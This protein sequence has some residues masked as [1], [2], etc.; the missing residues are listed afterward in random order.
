MFP[1][2]LRS[3]VE[4]FQKAVALAEE[5]ARQR[6][7][8][9]DG[10]ELFELPIH[11]W[12]MYTEPRALDELDFIVTHVTAVKGGFGVSK[13][14]LQRWEALLRGMGP[15]EVNTTGLPV[16]D[17]QLTKAGVWTPVYKPDSAVVRHYEMDAPLRELAHRLAL[18]ER[19]RGGVPYHQIGAANGDNVANRR[20]TP[21]HL[22][23][24]R[25]GTVRWVRWVRSMCRAP[26]T[27]TTGTSRPAGH[28]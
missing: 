17:L 12:K 23:L 11:K 2:A 7:F 8:S 10:F 20:T 4:N 26:K 25:S 27:W 6:Q 1:F 14:A 5:Q 13:K 21:R 22:A 16:I 9:A 28:L 15:G 24:V 18:W 19:Y 3:I